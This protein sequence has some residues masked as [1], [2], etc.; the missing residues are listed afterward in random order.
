MSEQAV[1]LCITDLPNDI[2]EDIAEFAGALGRTVL[3][4]VNKEFT[5]LVRGTTLQPE[6]LCFE[7]ASHN[8]FGVLKWAKTAGYP[9]TSVPCSA[10]YHGNLEMLKWIR[11]NGLITWDQ[12]VIDLTYNVAVQYGNLNIVEWM[13][14]RYDDNVKTLHYN[15]ARYGHHNILDWLIN[16]DINSI[17]F[18]DTKL[19]AI[20]AQAGQYGLIK[21]L[22]TTEYDC[23][24]DEMTFA[25]TAERGTLTMLKWLHTNGCPVDYTAGIAAA[26]A[27]HID[28]IKWLTSIGVSLHSDMWIE[29]IANNH[30]ELIE[31]LVK[32]NCPRSGDECDQAACYGRIEIL[33]C[34]L[35][36]NM[37]FIEIHLCWHAAAHGQL[38]TLKWLR[39]RGFPWSERISA[40]AAET[41][42]FE[43]LKWLHANGCPCDIEHCVEQIIG[44]KWI[45]DNSEKIP[46]RE[47]DSINTLEYFHEAGF[48]W[49]YPRLCLI[50]ARS[51]NLA[52]LKWLREHDCPW[53]ILD[54]LG[55]AKG[56]NDTDKWIRGEIERRRIRTVPGGNYGTGLRQ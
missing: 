43:V 8:Y 48:P 34:L 5:E 30:T 11:K 20:A 36:N 24:W 7:A 50:A 41:N 19:Y 45:I 28:I 25:Y 17:Y 46:V 31:W 22:H 23:L 40:I 29:A 51:G 26:R 42:R 13:Y 38:E 14:A 47:E 53:D 3:G 35:E 21:T 37:T 33:S 2:L 18:V 56:N 12:S 39:S 44:A 15:A 1:S 6:N 54:C 49:N 32:N 9:V 55:A 52:V 10:A 16:N 27:R 4:H